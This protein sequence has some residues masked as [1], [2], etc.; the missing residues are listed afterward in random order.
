M[1]L[2]VRLEKKFTTA[3]LLNEIKIL[4]LRIDSENKVLKVKDP[5]SYVMKLDVMITWRFPQNEV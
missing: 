3:C 1:L 2:D 5:I 4:P